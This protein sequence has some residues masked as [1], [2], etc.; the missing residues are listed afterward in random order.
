MPPNHRFST[1]R[2]SPANAPSSPFWSPL[3]PSDLAGYPS[4]RPLTGH[5][6]TRLRRTVLAQALMVEPHLDSV[7]RMQLSASLPI[8]ARR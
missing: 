3:V 6:T 7:R 5:Y 4:S 1:Y 8:S 2:L